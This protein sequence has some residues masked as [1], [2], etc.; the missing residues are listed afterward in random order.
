MTRFMKAVGMVSC[1][2]VCVALGACTANSDC[3]KEQQQGSQVNASVMS[4]KPQKS[5]CCA[6]GKETQVNASVMSDKPQKSGCSAAGKETQINASVMSEKSGCAG[7]SATECKDA[8][9][10]N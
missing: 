8:A 6:A 1:A 4:D 3:S 5:G 2:A 7:K 9:P 10:K